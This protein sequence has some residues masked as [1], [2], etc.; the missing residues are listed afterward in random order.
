M[1]ADTH[2]LCFGHILLA[3]YLRAE[4]TAGT[5]HLYIILMAFLKT[6]WNYFKKIPLFI[7]N[8]LSSIVLAIFYFTIFFVFAIIFRMFYGSS[9]KPYKT[10][11]NWR[12]KEAG[13]NGIAGFTSE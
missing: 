5:V 12:T 8:A 6:I 7:G 3:D 9:L 1:V 13:T 4:F 10:N 11:S 2:D